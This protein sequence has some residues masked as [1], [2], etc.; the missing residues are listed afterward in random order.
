MEKGL[1]REL[2]GIFRSDAPVLTT[3]HTY[4]LIQGFP[5]V[6]FTALFRWK[7]P[8]AVRYICKNSLEIGKRLGK[9]VFIVPFEGGEEPY[10]RDGS[11]LVRKSASQHGCEVELDSQRAYLLLSSVRPME[12]PGKD[13]PFI[14][15]DIRDLSETRFI[16][17]LSQLLDLFDCTVEANLFGHKR[18]KATSAGYALITSNSCFETKREQIVFGLRKI[19]EIRYVLG[20]LEMKFIGFPEAVIEELERCSQEILASQ[21]R[22][23]K[24]DE[25]R[26]RLERLEREEFS[27]SIPKAPGNG[28]A[29]LHVAVNHGPITHNVYNISGPVGVLG[30]DNGGDVSFA[31]GGD[32]YGSLPAN[33]LLEEIRKLKEKLEVPGGAPNPMKLQLESI[34]SH[35][36]EGKSSAAVSGLKKIGNW[37]LSVGDKATVPLLI[38]LVKKAI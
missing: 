18:K 6:Y 38:E 11:E 19:A 3:E 22:T 21:P 36:K 15:A 34:E 8:G 35:L 37:I 7:V 13:S 26:R 5:E 33:G 23:G 30:S 2:D 31:V 4:R 25:I 10:W 14:L 20:S 12:L 29:D 16:G 9:N 28:G 32:S 24:L 1:G 17:L 27:M